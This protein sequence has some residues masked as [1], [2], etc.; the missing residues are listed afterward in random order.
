MKPKRDFQRILK[1]SIT[2]KK[3]HIDVEFLNLLDE[4]MVLNPDKRLTV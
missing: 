3:K 1:E 2:E 4:I